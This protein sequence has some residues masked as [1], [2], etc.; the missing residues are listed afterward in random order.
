MPAPIKEALTLS[1]FA[2]LRVRAKA[3]EDFT[4]EHVGKSVAVM[5]VTGL[6]Y[7]G[8]LVCFADHLGSDGLVLLEMDDRHL[9]VFSSDIRAMEVDS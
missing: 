7:Y 6:T 4:L 8:T 1:P 2:R 3:I 9:A 5:T